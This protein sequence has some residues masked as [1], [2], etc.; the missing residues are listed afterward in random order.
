M[1]KGHRTQVKRDRN[2][3][4]VDKRPSAKEAK[5]MI[6][7]NMIENIL[8]A[9]KNKEDIKARPFSSAFCCTIFTRSLRREATL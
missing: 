4:Q 8:L 3:K 6:P 5:N 7:Q 2:E 9:Y 1:S